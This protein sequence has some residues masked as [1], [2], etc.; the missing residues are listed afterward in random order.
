MKQITDKIK[1]PYILLVGILYYILCYLAPITLS[2]D[3]L[4]KFI[5]PSDN[6]TYTTPISTLKD[7]L[8]SQYIH[9][10]VL[11]GRSIIH[12]IVQLFD[13]I[14]GKELCN[15]I[16]SIFMVCLIFMISNFITEKKNSILSYTLITT[17]LFILIPG[18]H[19]EFLLFVGVLNYLWVITATLF[20]II[21][22]DKNKDKQINKKIFALSSLSIFVGGL[23]EG[24]SVPILL[25][26][27]IFCFF[28]RNTISKSTILYCTIFY[29]IGTCLCVLSPGLAH[30]VAQDEGFS[31]MIVHKLFFGCINLLHLRI[32]YLMMVLSLIVYIKKKIIWQ[33]HFDRYKYFYLC[34]MFS[35]IPV[36]GSG[37]TESRVIFFTEFVA[38]IIT[39]DL[40][41]KLCNKKVGSIVCLGCNIIMLII[42][43][44]VFHYSLI[45]YKNNQYIVQ[46]LKNRKVF[47]IE[48]PQI[49]PINNVLLE[50]IFDNYIREPIKFGPFENAQGFVQ[51]NAHVK[52]MKILYGKN[53]L[54]FIP[55][56]I[57]ELINNKSLHI[58]NYVYN[59][60]KE[61]FIIRTE[62]DC[63]P[64]SVKLI[65][66]KEDINTLPFYKRMLAYKEDTYDI[67]QG[68][69][70][71]L[72]VNHQ[73]YVIAC[74]P[75][76]NISRR[77]K[78][79]TIK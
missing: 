51:S 33:E 77:I 24:F 6:E 60:N 45:N 68:Y 67:E 78:G 62:Y 9:Y 75:T 76:R 36:F 10:Q 48:V 44:I 27:I 34:W 32:T 4:Y 26:L 47:I 50:Y 41:L 16:S 19:N 42:Y 79:I 12:F 73:K 69:F 61:M 23:H 72:V 20:F 49:K 56:D 37:S 59:K 58:N 46:Q 5:W 39:I 38:M 2:D 18:F 63:I 74:C 1:L 8:S 43:I 66:N 53:K 3:L 11:N 17:M 40:I 21:L 22:L 54:Y 29:G 7:V 65:L 57:T 13:G 28:H 64:Q 52:C 71:T 70:D 15:I 14:L 35:F 30:R 31:Q 55:K 25:T